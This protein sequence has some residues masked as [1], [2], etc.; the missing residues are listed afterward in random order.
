MADS[1]RKDRHDLTVHVK[2][3]DD[4][5]V[6]YVSGLDGAVGSARR[7]EDA[8]TQLLQ[9]AAKLLYLAPDELDPEWAFEIGPYE[10]LAIDEVRHYQN[11]LAD[12]QMEYNQALHRAVRML[13]GAGYTDRDAAF[14]LRLSHQRIAQVRT[15]NPPTPPAQ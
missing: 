10:Q 6:A 5:W 4:G 8:T 9:R 12:A 3:D 7:L 11:V 1:S 2:R 15:A 13:H 14:L